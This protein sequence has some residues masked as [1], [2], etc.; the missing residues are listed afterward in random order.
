MVINSPL[1][2]Q[3][4]KIEIGYTYTDVNK[5]LEKRSNKNLA[6]LLSSYRPLPWMFYSWVLDINIHN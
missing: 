1:Y 5:H 2:L 4:D 3:N 6:L